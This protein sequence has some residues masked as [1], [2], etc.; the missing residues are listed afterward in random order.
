MKNL[1]LRNIC[2]TVIFLYACIFCYGGVVHKSHDHG[3]HDHKNL[4]KE[5]EGDGAYSPKDR[6]HFDVS[7][8]HHND[9][10]HEAILGSVKEADEYDHLPP[11]EAKKRLSIL[12]TKMDLTKDGFI[13]RNELK[14]WI[15]RSF[16]MLSE[17]EATEKLED[18]DENQDGRL[19]WTEY[20]SDT[21]GVDSDDDDSLKFHEENLHL[22]T[23]DREMWK[24][25]DKNG[26]DV[27]DF[28]EWL[29]FSNPEEHPEMLPI[30]LQQTLKNKDQDN[31]GAINFQEFI[32]DQ[33]PQLTKEALQGEKYKFDEE[34]DKDKDGKLTGNEILSWIVPT[35]DEIADDEVLHLFAHSDDDHDDLLSYDEIL[36][37]HEVFVG[38]EATDYGDHLHNIHQFDDEL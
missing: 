22:I 26:D 18:A 13:D 37:H 6:D 34:F 2:L 25:A 24:A 16:R 28:Q 1:S 38:S 7:G 19:S 23:E 29:V 27:L 30:I 4:N 31:D 17:E 14:A 33:G 5:R 12:I 20:L 9:F 35:N 21:Y 15:L 36:Q 11:E 8:G 32:G 3:H 10:D